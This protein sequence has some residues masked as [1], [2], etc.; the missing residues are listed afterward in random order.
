M[1]THAELSVNL[2]RQ[3]SGFFK[4][5]AA[6]NP[7]VRQDMLENAE[8]FDQVAIM[9]D[10]APTGQTGGKTHGAL[11]AGLL[12]DASGFF[13]S[14]GAQNPPVAEQMELNAGIFEQMAALVSQDP[15]DI[16]D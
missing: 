4:S 12:K 1:P 11:A 14:L 5:I 16:L 13:R 7:A 8:T 6:E 3:A 15:L 9:L 2:L 10:H